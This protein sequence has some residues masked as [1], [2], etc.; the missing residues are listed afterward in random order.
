MGGWNE[1]ARERNGL[2]RECKWIMSQGLPQRHVNRE[3]KERARFDARH[4]N[5]LFLNIAQAF[6]NLLFGTL[7]TIIWLSNSL[8]TPVPNADA[9]SAYVSLSLPLIQ[10]CSTTS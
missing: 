5:D 4:K 10:D 9:N 8:A 7:V 2:K 3:F 1:S 6:S